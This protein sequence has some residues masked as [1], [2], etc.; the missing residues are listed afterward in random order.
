[1]QLGTEQNAGDRRNAH[2]RGGSEL[3]LSM[4]RV[5]HSARGRGDQNRRERDSGRASLVEGECQ[6][7]QR[8]D[9]DATAD[10]EEGAE[11]SGRHTDPGQFDDGHAAYC[12]RMDALATLA[13]RPAEAALFLDVDGVLAPIVERPEDARVPPETRSELERLVRRYGLVACVT[14]RPSADA[15]GI[16]GVPALTY[17]GEHGLELAPEAGAWADRIRQFAESVLWPQLER[18]PFSLTFHYRGADDPAA[19]R[20]RLEPVAAAAADAGLRA[21]W[22]RMVLEVLPPLEASKGT[23]VRSLL[24]ASGLRRALYAGDDTT[25]L[26]GF[27]ALDGLDISVRVAVV[28]PEAPLELAQRAD[29][30]VDSPAAFLELLRSL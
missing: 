27:A 1:M 15:V 7:E 30:T 9:H 17:A 24:D 21:R 4:Q 25:D 29:V 20:A 18:K 13:S 6:A 3:D 11:E 10:A 26:D 16:V 2:E 14:G 8:H 5:G 22:G 19:Q 12:T 23:A 28:S